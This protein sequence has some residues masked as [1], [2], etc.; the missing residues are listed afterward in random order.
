MGKLPD[1]FMTAFEF[2]NLTDG[3]VFS[4]IKLIL[5]GL[6]QISNQQSLSFSE[7]YPER[8]P[9]KVKIQ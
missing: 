5:G 3:T 4:D 1:D 8:T 9:K 2:H 7:Q 6:I